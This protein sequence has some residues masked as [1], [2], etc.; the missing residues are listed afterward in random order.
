MTKDEVC[1]RIREIGIIPAIRVSSGEDAHFAIGAVASGIP[2]VKITV[3]VPGAFEL[4]SH[5]VE[6]H[7]KTIVAQALSSQQTWLA[8]VRIPAQTSLP[9]PGS[10]SHC[11]V[12]EQ[13]G[14]SRPARRIAPTEVVDAWIAG[15][16]FVKVSPCSE[17][18]GE[19]PSRGSKP[20]TSDL[21]DRG[22]RS[23]SADRCDSNRCRSCCRS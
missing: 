3:T 18:G 13:G 23:K 7:R 8:N 21:I 16:D 4:I 9:R 19:S 10:T 17:V 15:A 22:R 12:R 5:L 11:G 6:H 2:M 14:A 20:P 1:A